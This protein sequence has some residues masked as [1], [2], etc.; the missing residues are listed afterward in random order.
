MPV[1]FKKWIVSIFF[2]LWSCSFGHSF[3]GGRTLILLGHYWGEFF[4]ILIDYILFRVIYNE[5]KVTCLLHKNKII[6]FVKWIGRCGIIRQW[7]FVFSYY[8]FRAAKKKKKGSN[9]F[10][11]GNAS[12]WSNNL[13]EMLIQQAVSV[14]G[15]GGG[16]KR[17]G[18]KISLE[19]L[20]ISLKM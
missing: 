7:A 19:I 17:G 10:H 5:Y 14:W 2:S 6:V 3:L 9:L 8:R 12:F 15:G 18:F 20:H 11:L 4:F 1:F 16:E 13:S